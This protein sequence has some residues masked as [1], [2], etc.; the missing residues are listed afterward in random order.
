[1]PGAVETVVKVRVSLR[2]VPSVLPGSY[3]KVYVVPGLRP[4]TR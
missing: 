1:M 4:V 3:S 2:V